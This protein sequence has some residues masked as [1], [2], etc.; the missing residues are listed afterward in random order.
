MDKVLVGILTLVAIAIASAVAGIA[1]SIASPDVFSQPQV[2]VLPIHGFISRDLEI[3]SFDMEDTLSL[4][5]DSDSDPKIAAIVLDIDSSGGTP[6][7]TEMLMRA[8]ASTEKPVV[9]WIGGTGASGGYFVASASDYIVSDP[10][11]ITGSVGAYSQVPSAEGLL[12]KIGLKIYT[13][14]SGEFKSMG[15]PE[16][17]MTEKEMELMQGVIDEIHKELFSGVVERRNL[18][19]E[20]AAIVSDGRILLGKQ[21]LGLGLVDEIGGRETAISRAAKMANVTDYEWTY[22]ETPLSFS[23]LLQEMATLSARNIGVGLSQGLSS[24]TLLSIK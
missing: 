21:A 7:A 4:I 17:N 23:E 9:A 8:I 5:E 1:I 16:R 20:Q 14:S 3:R 6:V 2:A 19:T 18:T 13:F 12:E 10:L 11:S 22:L 15:S 24:E